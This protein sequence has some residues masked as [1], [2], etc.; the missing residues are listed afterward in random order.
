MDT[1]LE[2]I[3]HR[4]PRLA[5]FVQGGELTRIPR[6]PAIAAKLYAAVAAQLPKD[7][8][9]SETEVNNLLRPIHDDVSTLRRAL[10][11]HGHLRR[12]ADGTRYECP[13]TVTD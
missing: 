7:V 6:R 9:M 11:D 3:V 13:A 1:P 10:V 2:R 8:T 5:A 12:S 4:E